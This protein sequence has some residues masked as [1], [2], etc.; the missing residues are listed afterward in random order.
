VAYLD[1]RGSGVN[2]LAR[3]DAPHHERLINDV[4]QFIH[5]LSRTGFDGLP[6]TLAAVSWGG[7]LATVIALQ[8]PNLIDSLLLVT[9]GVCANVRAST[10]QT[11]AL[12]AASKS[13]ARQRLIPIPLDDPALFTSSRPHQQFIRND[14]LTLRKVTLRFLSANSALDAQLRR[15]DH[16]LRC[17]TLVMLAGQDQIVNN[18]ET[19][20]FFLALCSSSASIIEYPSAVHTLEFENDCDRYIFD[21]LQWLETASL[22]RAGP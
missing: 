2:S 15:P 8:Q 1:R 6:R 16:R 20:H 7:K 17:P 14:P 13:N 5:H 3:G 12:Q 19:R 22:K 21:M 11:F 18:N 10:L 4:V 9:P